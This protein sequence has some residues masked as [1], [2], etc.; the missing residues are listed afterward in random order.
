MWEYDDAGN[1]LSRTEYVYTT[2]ELDAAVDIAVDTVYYGYGNA[3]WGDLLMSYDGHDIEYDAIGNPL[4]YYNGSRWTFTWKNGRELAT[5]TRGSRAWT[6]TYDANGLRT[7]RVDN[8][9]TEPMTYRYFYNGSL[10][11][12]MVIE[13][14]DLNINMLFSYGADG[15]PMV[16]VYEGIPYY[17]V[18][19]AQGDVVALLNTS[20]D[21]VV[22]YSYDAWGNPLSTTGSLASTLGYY[23]PLRYRGYVYDTETG[24]YYLQSRYYDP[25]TGRFLNADAFASTGQGILSNNTFAY[26]INNPVI[27]QDSSG[28]AVETVFDIISLGTSIV[29]VTV[30]PWD[31]WAWLGLV[32]DVADVALLGVGGLG[33]AV[34]VLKAMG[35]IDDTVDAVNLTRKTL[36][37][38]STTANALSVGEN[39]VYLSYSDAAKNVLEYVGITNCYGRRETEWDGIRKIDRYID[40]VDRN[41]ARFA[42]QTIIGLFGKKGNTLS[43]IRNS[44]SKHGKLVDGYIDFF[45]RLF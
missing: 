24:F 39:F 29:G 32:G 6:N 36:E 3:N 22:Q 23:N 17:Y 25:T 19:N 7:M 13:D 44:I 26:C 21:V 8:A 9:V 33:E 30:N 16:V 38:I 34:K 2:E 14:I 45:M 28:H 41:T 35:A 15:R 11:S 5:M 27:Y 42:E 4:S 18:T 37:V 31:P 10:L 40:G 43:N 12:R 1:I 20:G